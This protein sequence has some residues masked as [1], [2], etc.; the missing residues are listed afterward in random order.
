[1]LPRG[2]CG[3]E[4]PSL[5]GAAAPKQSRLSRR[6]SGL[7]RFA[8][9]DVIP[10]GIH[11]R[12]RGAIA[13]ELCIRR[14]PSQMRGRREGRVL[15]TPMAR[16]QQ[17]KLAAVTTGWPNIRPS[18]H[19]GFNA[20]V[21]LSL[22]TGLYCSHR[23]R[24]HHLA[25]L[26]PASGCQDHTILRPHQRRSSARMIVRVAPASIAFRLTCRDDR[27]TP[28]ASRRDVG[29]KSHFSEKRKQNI[30]PART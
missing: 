7:L 5:R 27:D 22:G 20:Y 23:P 17:E 10:L 11:K 24:D 4:A 6:D 30:F 28:S 16:Q 26:T 14:R 12:S 29:S 2:C 3:S 8:R 21:A 15:A 13:P 18:L 9:N 25:G 1:M 19:D